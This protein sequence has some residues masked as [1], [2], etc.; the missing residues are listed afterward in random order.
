MLDIRKDGTLVFQEMFPGA[1][2]YF[3]QGL[4]GYIYHCIGEYPTNE[5][6]GVFT[7]ATSNSEVPITD[8][9]FINDVYENILEY[10]EKGTFIY[11]RYEDLPQ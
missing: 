8:F 4:S 1:L 3:Y 2:S 7:C 10:Q 11:E 6:S 5:D 9:E